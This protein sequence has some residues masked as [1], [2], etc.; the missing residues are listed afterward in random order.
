[1]SDENFDETATH[2]NIILSQAFDISKIQ[3]LNFQKIFHS[4]FFCFREM[5][6]LLSLLAAE[7]LR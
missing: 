1:M 5:K 6:L 7:A 3:T 4:K 2:L